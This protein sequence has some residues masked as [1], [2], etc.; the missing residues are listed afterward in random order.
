LLGAISLYQTPMPTL[1]A[2][3]TKIH[4]YRQ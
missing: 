2:E 4:M 3:S 1:P